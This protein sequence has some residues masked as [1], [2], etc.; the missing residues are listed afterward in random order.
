MRTLRHKLEMMSLAI[1]ADHSLAVTQL[2]GVKDLT[3]NEKSRIAVWNTATGEVI[4]EIPKSDEYSHPKFLHDGRNILVTSPKKAVV[5]SVDNSHAPLIFRDVAQ[6]SFGDEITFSAISPA[7]ERIIL[8]LNSGSLLIFNSNGQLL[9]TIDAALVGKPIRSIEFTPDGLSFVTGLENGEIIYWNAV[10]GN[11]KSIRDAVS[12]PESAWVAL[13]Q[14][15]LLVNQR[16]INERDN[17]CGQTCAVN[18]VQAF[19]VQSGVEPHGRP[20]DD[21][22]FLAARFKDST[23]PFEVMGFIRELLQKRFPTIP[24]Q[25]EAI[26]ISGME[27][28]EGRSNIKILKTIDI[29]DLTP[30]EGELKMVAVV[31]F[32]N[33][34]ENLGQHWVNIEGIAENGQITL[35]DPAA[36]FTEIT[37][38]V[39]GTQEVND[40]VVPMIF[41]TGDVYA[42]A[43]TFVPIAVITLK[44][45][46]SNR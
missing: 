22:S 10:D 45:G 8:G 32:N 16:S 26:E 6:L 39:Q 23:G 31:M 21:L 35:V 34:G 41:P 1:N 24:A 28:V 42:S 11:G 43:K 37:A 33:N 30:Q 27:P 9:D 25:I 3:M 7:G 46:A 44:K 29:A 19:A 5:F 14:N 12:V 20:Q 36:P 38:F 18:I 17:L 2:L 4:H 13:R 40:S 15:R